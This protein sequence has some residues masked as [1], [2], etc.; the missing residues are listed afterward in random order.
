MSCSYMRYDTFC[1]VCLC[2]GT[3]QCIAQTA[4]HVHAGIAISVCSG[5]P[6]AASQMC[7]GLQAASQLE[8]VQAPFPYYSTDCQSALQLTTHFQ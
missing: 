8:K 1:I 4:M 5:A 3:E 6:K 7:S 2:K